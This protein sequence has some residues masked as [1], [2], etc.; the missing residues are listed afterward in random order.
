MVPFNQCAIYRRFLD[1]F[2]VILSGRSQSR[3]SSNPRVLAPSSDI[4]PELKD[5]VYALSD[6]NDAIIAAMNSDNS[7]TVDKPSLFTLQRDIIFP[8][9]SFLVCVP[10]S[11]V[12]SRLLLREPLV[13]TAHFFICSLDDLVVVS[14]E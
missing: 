14:L 12:F 9:K 1:E 2:A 3:S 8:D 5:A 6:V 13:S 10:L 11:L 4:H 7:V